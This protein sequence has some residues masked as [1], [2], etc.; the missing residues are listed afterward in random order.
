MTRPDTLIPDRPSP[1]GRTRIM[2]SMIR[3]LD[4]REFHRITTAEIAR[5]AEVTEGLIY[6]SE[7]RKTC[8]T[9]C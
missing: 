8:S 7:T 1:P 9:R 5:D 2:N 3:L 6:K 4:V